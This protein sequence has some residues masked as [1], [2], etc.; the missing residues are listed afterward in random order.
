MIRAYANIP[1]YQDVRFDA[2]PWFAES[3]PTAIMALVRQEWT[4]QPARDAA[5]TLSRLDGYADLAELLD[6]KRRYRN[7][8]SGKRLEIEIFVD[9]EDALAWL[10]EHRP[11]IHDTINRTYG[12]DALRCDRTKTYWADPQDPDE[13]LYLRPA[14]PPAP[15]P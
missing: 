2:A 7:D 10:S 11:E 14:A 3:S 8:I 6:Y 5:R 15:R 9:P 13:A 4:G 12:D 1:A